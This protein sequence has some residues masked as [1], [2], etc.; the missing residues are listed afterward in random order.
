VGRAGFDNG[1]NRL[2]RLL[3]GD[4]GVEKGLRYGGG[5]LGKYLV[6][7]GG[8]QTK[9]EHNEREKTEAPRRS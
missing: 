7:L 1:G 8:N 9:R 2:L 6:G 5:I 4:G 3:A